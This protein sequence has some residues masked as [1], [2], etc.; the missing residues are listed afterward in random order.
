M[1]TENMVMLRFDGE[2]WQIAPGHD[3]DENSVTVRKPIPGQDDRA[4]AACLAVAGV[5]LGLVVLKPARALPLLRMAT[6]L[7]PLA[8]TAMAMLRPVPQETDV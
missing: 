4:I 1:K 6:S 3:T 8:R 5:V 2:V 7:W